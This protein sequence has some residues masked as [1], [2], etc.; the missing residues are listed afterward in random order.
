MVLYNSWAFL[1]A[2]GSLRLI[3]AINCVK[4]I[5]YVSKHLYSTVHYLTVP[6]V[7]DMVTRHAWPLYP[8]Q[9]TVAALSYW[10]HDVLRECMM[11]YDAVSLFSISLRTI[12]LNNL[13]DYLTGHRDR[14]KSC[15]FL[16]PHDGCVFPML[17]HSPVLKI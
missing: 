10:T 2:S 12:R 6:H 3:I 5:H 14:T 11:P 1:V 16:V 4:P 17:E 7:R 8:P 9:T 15:N 13:K